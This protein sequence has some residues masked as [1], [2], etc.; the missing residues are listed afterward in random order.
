MILHSQISIFREEM[1]SF[2]RDWI[3]PTFH[4]SPLLF[5]IVFH[6]STFVGLLIWITTFKLDKETFSGRNILNL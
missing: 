5:I 2:A 6:I 4:F 3:D 1:E